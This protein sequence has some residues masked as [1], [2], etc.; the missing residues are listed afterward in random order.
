MA[1]RRAQ[2]NTR[3]MR[4]NPLYEQ[5][6]AG[7]VRALI[8]ANPWATIVSQTSDGIVA[9]HYPVLLDDSSDELAIV[10]HV[11]RPDELNH[12]FGSS[13]MLLIVAG[14]HGYI[15]PSWYTDAA[16]EVPTWNFTV[17]HCYGVPEVLEPEE[18]LRVLT[19]LVDHFEQHVESPRP[20]N[21]E[22]GAQLSQY[23]VGLRL[24]ITRFIFKNKMS[25]DKDLQS[26]V[27]VIEQLRGDGPYASA[28][29]ADAMQLA[30]DES[31]A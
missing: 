18:N 17:A 5:T 22:L 10:T 20:L 9:S 4:H 30:L 12:R 2:R 7:A 6:D 29:I 31:Q 28:E 8:A 11:G 27:Q 16:R 14:P 23:T 13:E 21:Q 24:P 1:E 19:K 15:S 26:R 3:S 25:Q